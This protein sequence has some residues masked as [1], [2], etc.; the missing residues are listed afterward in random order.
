LRE[1]DRVIDEDLQVSSATDHLAELRRCDR[2]F[3]AFDFPGL[4]QLTSTLIDQETERGDAFAYRC[5][6]RLAESHKEA[7]SGPP[8]DLVQLLRDYFQACERPVA[9]E[10]AIVCRLFLKLMFGDLVKRIARARPG[11]RFS[12]QKSDPLCAGAFAILD[13]D[14]DKAQEYFSVAVVDHGSRVYAYAGLALLKLFFE[15]VEGAQEALA[16]A[17]LEDDDVRTLAASLPT[18]LRTHVN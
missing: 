7:G 4:S 18:D 13:G 15:D 14:F 6:A 8:S 3:F 16:I 12:L 11:D 5:F 17:G 2:L 1:H 10:G 9:T